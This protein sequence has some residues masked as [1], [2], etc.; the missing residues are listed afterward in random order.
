ME[1]RSGAWIYSVV[2]L[3]LFVAFYLIGELIVLIL[4]I[5]FALIGSF[6]IK[7]AIEEK[8]SL[9]EVVSLLKELPGRKK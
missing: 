2:A 9:G 3:G 6:W 4:A 5:F 1:K 7:R 8:K